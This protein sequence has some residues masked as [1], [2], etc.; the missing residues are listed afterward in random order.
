MIFRIEGHYF[1]QRHLSRDTFLDNCINVLCQILQSPNV[2]LLTTGKHIL[3]RNRKHETGV[4]LCIN[5]F[6]NFKN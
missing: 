6:L 5:N 1:Y 3:A 4:R 2:I